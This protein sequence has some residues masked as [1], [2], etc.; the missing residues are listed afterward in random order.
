MASNPTIL[1]VAHRARVSVGTVSNVLNDRGNVSEGRRAKVV[2]AMSALGYV[3]NMSAQSL[4]GRE[5]HVIGLC[6]PVTGSAYFMALLE[7]FESLA[8]QQGYQLM[9]VISHGDPAL[10]LRRVQALVGRNIDGLILIPTHDAKASLEL[11]AQRSIPAVVV[12][13][14]ILDPRFD[15]VAIDDRKAMRDATAHVIALGH[16]RIAYF[17]RDPRLSVVQHRIHGFKDA[18]SA[19]RPAVTATIIQRNPS[20]DEFSVQVTEVLSLAKPPTVLIASNSATALLLVRILQQ[21]GMRWP[22]DISLLAFDEPVWAQ[23]V[24]PPLAVVRHPTQQIAAEA[25]NRLLLRLREPGAPTTRTT[26]EAHLVSGPSLG[27]PRSARRRALIAQPRTSKEG[28]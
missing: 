3:P 18:T 19:A 4:R 5:S 9:Q 11:L 16:R 27:P 8:A 1:D 24:T 20:D 6:T 15:H 26:L 13:P 21:R 22:D 17:V 14:V 12:D 28:R 7:M 23:V 10:E 25:W 2:A